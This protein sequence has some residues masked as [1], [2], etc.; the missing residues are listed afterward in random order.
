[1]AVV[2]LDLGGVNT[3]TLTSIVGANACHIA[4]AFGRRCL[5]RLLPL[6]LKQT[7]LDTVEAL[8]VLALGVESHQQVLVLGRQP[9]EDAH[10]NV[11]L[12]HFAAHGLEVL[13]EVAHAVHVAQHALADGHFDG[14]ELTSRLHLVHRTLALED[15]LQRRPH[16]R[17][18][19][20][21]RHVLEL[22]RPK[23]EPDDG[24]RLRVSTLS[25]RQLASLRVR[26]LA[27]FV[28]HIVQ[29]AQR[30]DHLNALTPLVEVRFR[31]LVD[32]DA[33]HTGK[34]SVHDV[35]LS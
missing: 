18:R 21:A 11:H 26:R 24:A 16:F 13:A 6:L 14:V 32:L 20:A 27:V 22:L 29:V 7:A 31:Q 25:Q 34:A 23:G 3:A 33:A 30:E 12:R 15:T 5:V 9:V 19:L 4:N 2:A 17:R 8:V 35:F 28:K 10:S 1:M